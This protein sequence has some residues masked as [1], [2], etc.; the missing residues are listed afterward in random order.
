MLVRHYGNA[1]RADC[2]RAFDSNAPRCFLPEE[3]IQFERFL[4][5][6]PGPYFVI[7]DVDDV[8]ACGG[9]ATGR[10]AS[11]ADICWTIVHRDHQGHGVGHFL[12][13]TCVAEILELEPLKSVRLETS[14]HTRAFFER[15]GFRAVE[16]VPNGLGP[17]L[18]R[19]EMRVEL[20]GTARSHWQE[21]ITGGLPPPEVEEPI[22]AIESY[23]EW[24]AN[25]YNPGHYLGGRLEPHLDQLRTGRR[26]KRLAGL[27]LGLSALIA[28][29]GPLSLVDEFGRFEIIFGFLWTAVIWIAAVR[30]YAKGGA[31]NADYR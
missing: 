7:V 21:M 3:R 15:W 2:L 31:S 14:Q 11:Q 22:P 26:G 25:R 29:V 8:V 4:D 18:D 5:Q 28:T 10:V 23:K 9:F 17:G 24:S 13:T 1:D 6:L 20:D 19:V 16:V 27:F 12:M 30:M